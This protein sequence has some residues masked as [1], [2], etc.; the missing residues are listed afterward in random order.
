M[1]LKGDYIINNMIFIQFKSPVK[2]RFDSE[3]D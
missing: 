2:S 3:E 1:I